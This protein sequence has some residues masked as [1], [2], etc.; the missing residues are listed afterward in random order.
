MVEVEEWRILSLNDNYQVS[1]LGRV[2]NKK[3]KRILKPSRCGGYMS[4]GLSRNGE[5]KTF[6]VH[7]L[8]GLCFIENSENKPQINHIDKQGTNNNITI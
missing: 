2:M 6:S 1:N 3:T 4:V 5:T 7:K 8:V